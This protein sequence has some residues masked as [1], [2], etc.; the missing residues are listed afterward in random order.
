MFFHYEWIYSNPFKGLR[1]NFPIEIF[2][3]GNFILIKPYLY[4]SFDDHCRSQI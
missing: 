4:Y 1:E 2:T 3:L